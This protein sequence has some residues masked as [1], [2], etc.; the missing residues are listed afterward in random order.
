ML[1]IQQQ[2][3]K[4][5]IDAH[6]LNNYEDTSSTVRIHGFVQTLFIGKFGD[7]IWS[8]YQI[9]MN[10]RKFIDRNHHFYRLMSKEKIKLF[11]NCTYFVNEEKKNKLFTDS[12]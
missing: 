4:R 6:K 1:C 11:K 7:V 2:I 8:K 10:C 3:R 12:L 9:F 5:P